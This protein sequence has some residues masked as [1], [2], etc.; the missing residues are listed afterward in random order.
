[1][2]LELDEE[3]AMLD[4]AALERHLERCDR[5]RLSRG[6]LDALTRELRGAAP[7]GPAWPIVVTVPQVRRR[8]VRAG[9]AALVAAGAVA[10]GLSVLPGSSKPTA[11]ALGF[12][13]QQ[14]QRA[15]GRE[16]VSMEPAP[17]VVVT[18]PPESFA[19]RALR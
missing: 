13:D 5:C 1:M 10:G 15:F 2:S 3:I 16:H 18:P 9:L 6:E 8:L 12:I 19:S 4:R 7:E 17:N 14:E 11:S